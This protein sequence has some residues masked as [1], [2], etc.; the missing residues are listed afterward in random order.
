ME[1]K[2]RKGTGGEH[3]CSHFSVN[4][5]QSLHMMKMLSR[6]KACAAQPGSQFLL[7]SQSRRQTPFQIQVVGTQALLAPVRAVIVGTAVL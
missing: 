1:V 2:G 5:A 4:Q 7:Q 6:L 3:T